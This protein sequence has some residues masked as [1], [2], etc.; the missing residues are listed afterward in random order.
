M[1]NGRGTEAVAVQ[2]TRMTTVIR[3]RRRVPE[4][5]TVI[6]VK[7]VIK[8]VLAAYPE[9][10]AVFGRQVTPE[11]GSPSLIE[12]GYRTFSGRQRRNRGDYYDDVESA[13]A[14]AIARASMFRAL[15]PEDRTR[16]AEV[17]AVHN[18][19]KGDALFAEGILPNSCTQSCPDVSRG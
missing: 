3:S 16:L 6:S 19:D 17:S 10:R 8:D 9:T 1:V 4:R 12:C 14:D 2:Q 15:P 18:Y 13:A 7:T 5:G 11:G